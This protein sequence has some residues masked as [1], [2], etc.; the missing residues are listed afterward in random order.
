V[1][2]DVFVSHASEDKESFVRGLANQ[3]LKIGCKVW[4]DE[5]SL[6][7]GDSLSRSIDRGL[8]ESRYGIVVLSQHFLSKGW[9]DYE[10]RGLITRE[11]N[12][13]KVI[14]PILH[15]IPIQDVAKL[16]PTLADK[17][18]LDTKRADMNA[19]CSNILAI[20]RPDIY[21]NLAKTLLASKLYSESGGDWFDILRQVNPESPVPARLSSCQIV[22]LR[23]I[24][25]LLHPF[26]DHIGTEQ[27]L[28]IASHHEDPELDLLWWENLCAIF[29]DFARNKRVITD[30]DK[31]HL[32]L[33]YLV[34]MLWKQPFAETRE[35]DAWLSKEDKRV[36]KDIMDG[37]CMI[38]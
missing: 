7:V 16:S 29:M 30:T 9:P 3:L 23:I 8:T 20:I 14:L 5:F 25:G 28:D 12:G 18:A 35:I 1:K 17:I 6:Q 26:L 36:L 31:L 2:Y 34:S 10:L 13:E 32:L 11:V 19:I 22:R 37:I 4:Y 24:R 15:G 33:R 38:D 27:W 21:R